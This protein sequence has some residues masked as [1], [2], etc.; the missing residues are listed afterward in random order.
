MFAN[1]AFEANL[2]GLVMV[3]SASKFQLELVN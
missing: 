1:L 3:F 2:K